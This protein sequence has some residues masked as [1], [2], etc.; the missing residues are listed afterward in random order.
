MDTEDLLRDAIIAFMS[1][2]DAGC[3]LHDC[4]RAVLDVAEDRGQGMSG[5]GMEIVSFIDAVPDEKGPEISLKNASNERW[6]LETVALTPGIFVAA[7]P[8]GNGFVAVH[9][10]GFHQWWR[11]SDGECDLEVVDI[12]ADVGPPVKG[13]IN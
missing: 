13:A 2:R 4:V 8:S 6:T 7:H 3:Q 9:A 5:P 1:A 10:G 11:H 12:T